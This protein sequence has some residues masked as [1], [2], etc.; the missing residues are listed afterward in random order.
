M[1]FARVFYL[2]EYAGEVKMSGIHPL[3][4]KRFEKSA[5]DITETNTKYLKKING[6]FF[7]Q[8]TS[9]YVICFTLILTLYIGY[10]TLVTGKMSAGDFVATFNGAISLGGGIIYM[11]TYAMRQFTERSRMIEKYRTFLNM[12]NRRAEEF[13]LRVHTHH[14]I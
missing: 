8:E 3:L 13:P 6:L 10:Q 14:Y 2:Q 4:R 12:H 1:S 11:T 7:F 9:I 5:D